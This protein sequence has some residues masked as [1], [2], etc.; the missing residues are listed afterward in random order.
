M[1]RTAGRIAGKTIAL[2]VMG[3]A[4]LIALGFIAVYGF[5]WFQRSTADFRGETAALEDIQADPN[6]RISAYEH[7]FSLCASIQGHEETIKALEAEL[8]QGVSESREEQIRGAITANKSQRDGKIREY[9]LD[10]QRDYTA[11]Q[12]RDADLPEHLD[13]EAEETQCV[14][15][16]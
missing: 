16:S 7:F 11:G 9:N 3:V 6:S 15:G 5:G 2:W 8:A 1:Y 10:A 14:S 13:I 4:L 12:F